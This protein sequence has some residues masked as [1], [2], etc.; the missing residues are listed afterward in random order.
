[1][2]RNVSID[3]MKLYDPLDITWQAQTQ[4]KVAG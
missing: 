2:D 3:I 4:Q 1:M